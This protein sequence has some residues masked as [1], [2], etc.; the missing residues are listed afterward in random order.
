MMRRELEANEIGLTIDKMRVSVQNVPDGLFFVPSLC[1]Q[2]QRSM[3]AMEGIWNIGHLLLFSIPPM[4]DSAQQTTRS[5]LKC[6]GDPVR[7]SQILPW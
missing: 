1:Q 7:M 3:R 5:Q 4:N 2:K 6:V